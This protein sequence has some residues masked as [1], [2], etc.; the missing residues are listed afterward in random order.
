[1]QYQILL[2]MVLR[3]RLRRGTTLLMVFGRNTIKG[4]GRFPFRKKIQKFRCEFPGISQWEKV[5]PFCHKFRLR[6]GARCLKGHQ[7]GGRV[8]I[9]VR[10]S[11]QVCSLETNAFG[12]QEKRY[13]FPRARPLNPMELT[14]AMKLNM[15]KFLFISGFCTR[16][17]SLL[18]S[19]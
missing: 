7:H 18:L 13:W 6:W 17:Y 15:C 9:D 19:S 4:L 2:N 11:C 10:W 16:L 8:G 12:K 3:E 1:M 14:D 5:V